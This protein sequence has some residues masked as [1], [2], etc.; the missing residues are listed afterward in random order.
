VIEKNY[1]VVYKDKV[2]LTIAYSIIYET[3]IAAESFSCGFF[4]AL[5]QRIFD[6]DKKI[7]TFVI[8]GGTVL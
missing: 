8:S 2:N 6:K 5:I 4:Y 7:V 3:N 1:L